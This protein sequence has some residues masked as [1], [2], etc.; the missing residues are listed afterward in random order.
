VQPPPEVDED[1][2]AIM[3][4]REQRRE[5]RLVDRSDVRRADAQHAAINGMPAEVR[6]FRPAII[7][8]K[9]RG[10]L[11]GLIARTTDGCE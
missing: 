11:K 4:H 7:R 1:R 8:G 5:Q 6:H 9:R 10:W 3:L 2:R